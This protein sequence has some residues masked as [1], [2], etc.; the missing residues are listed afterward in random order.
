MVRTMVY[1]MGESRDGGAAFWRDPFAAYRPRKDEIGEPVPL[2]PQE[3]R[4]LWRD[5]ASLFLDP[6]RQQ[7]GGTLRPSVLDQIDALADRGL[8]P[9]IEEIHVRCVGMRTDMKAKIFEWV[10]QGLH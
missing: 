4:A 3:G 1:N 9:T 6:S 5:Y 10:D 8:L 7:P 2:R